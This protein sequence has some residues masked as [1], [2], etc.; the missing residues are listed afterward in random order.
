MLSRVA[1]ESAFRLKLV[2][3]VPDLLSKNSSGSGADICII[4]KLNL[5]SV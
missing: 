3:L 4:A 5:K 1:K 2:S